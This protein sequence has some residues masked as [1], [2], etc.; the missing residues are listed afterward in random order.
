MLLTLIAN[1]G[2]AAGIVVPEVASIPLYEQHGGAGKKNIREVN[3]DRFLIEFL[4]TATDII[5]N[6]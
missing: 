1:L 2:Y 3:N 6:Q 5:N 4:K